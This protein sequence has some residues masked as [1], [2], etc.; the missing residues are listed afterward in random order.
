MHGMFSGCETLTNLD[1]T[2]FDTAEVTTMEA[3]FKD[4]INLKTIDLKSINTNNVTDMS[5]MF[6]D[7]KV[8]TTLDLAH[9]ATERVTNMSY[10]FSGCSNLQSIDIKKLNLNNVT[11]M[12]Y[13]LAH[14]DSLKDLDLS[15]L[16]L[17]NVTN[18]GFMLTS[19]QS[20]Q[21]VSLTALN[22]PMLSNMMGTFSFCPSL[23]QVDLS[24]TVLPELL[25][26]DYTFYDDVQLRDVDLEHLNAPSLVSLMLT[27]NNCKQLSAID[28]SSLDV[29]AL[30]Y[31]VGTFANCSSL[32]S[33]NLKDFNAKQINYF[34]W[35]FLNDSSLTSLDLSNLNMQSA[36]EVTRMFTEKL[37]ELTS[38]DDLLALYQN[39][40]GLAID[41]KFS[42][43]QDLL[44]GT[45]A[46]STLIVGKNTVLSGAAMV[47]SVKPNSYAGYWLSSTNPTAM[48]SGDLMQLYKV[49]SQPD[50]LITYQRTVEPTLS[51]KAQR[52]THTIGVTPVTW[53]ATNNYQGGTDELGQPIDV[54]RIGI[55]WNQ[56]LNLQQPG[57]YTV[58]YAYKTKDGAYTKLNQTVVKV[59][60]PV[61]IKLKSTDVTMYIGPETAKWQPIDNILSTS[62]EQGQPIS[63]TRLSYTIT[64]VARSLNRQLNLQQP[65]YYQINYI[66]TDNN[67]NRQVLATAYLTLLQSDSKVTAQNVT[68]IAD[69][70][71]QWTSDL[72]QVTAIDETGRLVSKISTQVLDLKTHRVVKSPDTSQAG[73]YQITF[74]FVD[75]TSTKIFKTV[76]LTIL[77]NLAAIDT[78]SSQLTVGEQWHA[79][80]NLVGATDYAGNPLTI[81]DLKID[82]TVNW[83]QPGQY[84]VRYTYDKHPELT[85]IIKT[86][87]ITV[88]AAIAPV[89]PT[90]PGNGDVQPE[91]SPAPEPSQPVVVPDQP[92]ENHQPVPSPV[93]TINVDTS[94][95]VKKTTEV[96]SKMKPIMTKTTIDVKKGTESSS[97]AMVTSRREQN[98]LSPANAKISLAPNHQTA[99]TTLPKTSDTHTTTWLTVLGIDLLGLL[100]L[101][102]FS[103]RIK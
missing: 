64:S 98:Q 23:Q 49:N 77:A 70:R 36:Q 33:V 54:N 84:L 40:S 56:P 26:L 34:W 103:R 68:L 94:K 96:K 37:T 51:L 29:P 25:G 39:P 20:L 18:M 65:G 46:L 69:K 75:G 93:S 73:N 76:K 13:M 27:F 102:G 9:L 60:Y 90:D 53:S 78:R 74:S 31:F 88:V 4:C 92:A 12:S 47:N 61:N 101:I 16:S 79:K 55:T 81:N 30:T 15:S 59:V 43:V 86:A 57:T 8:L 28:L 17:P 22:A 45:T 97:N 99:T 32:K 10:M 50:S 19:C 6:N 48:T 80:D 44:K 3:M 5:H 62:D 42:G 63:N 1:L 100:S 87:L 67:G 83:Q 14:C 52:V 95:P 82:G 35:V 66:Y 89:N 7:C 71:Q 58:I 24:N 2:S 38:P 72:H 41:G 85:P 21:T 11:D 91:P